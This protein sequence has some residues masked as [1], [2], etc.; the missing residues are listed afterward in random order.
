MKKIILIGSGV[1][2]AAIIAAVVLVVL[3]LG[4]LIKTAVETYGPPI[5]KTEVRL[6]SA[7]I[8]ILSGS[9]SPG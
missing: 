6:G 3:N 1:V 8:S 7:D 9:G 2:V 4:G 5:T